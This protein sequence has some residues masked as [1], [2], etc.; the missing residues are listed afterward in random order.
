MVN[1]P[2]VDGLVASLHLDPAAEGEDKVFIKIVLV[3]REQLEGIVGNVHPIR[4]AVR[5]D[6]TGHV[7]SVAKQAETWCPIADHTR[8]DGTRMDAY[9]QR[10]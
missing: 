10:L 5:L 7:D 4:Y 6:A 9:G 1:V 8:H 3:H 2:N